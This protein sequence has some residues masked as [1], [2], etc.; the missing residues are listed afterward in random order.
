MYQFLKNVAKAL[1]PKQVLVANEDFF[2]GILK[3]FYRGGEYEC[4]VCENSIKHFI[5]DNTG[6]LCPLC[7]SLPRSR[8]LKHIVFNKYKDGGQ[9][10]LHFS[11][12]RRLKQEFRKL[13]NAYESADFEP[14]KEDLQLDIQNTG[15][16]DDNF[17]LIICFHVLEHV[18]EDRKAISELYRILKKG[19]TVLLQ[20]PFR[21]GDTIED[22]EV[23]DLK[24]RLQL[25][26]QEDHVRWYGFND[27]K[28]RIEAAGFQCE[29]IRAD[30]EMN[31][32]LRLK[33]GINAD[34]RVIAARKL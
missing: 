21:D 15:L 4:S 3:S 14:G 5:Q 10:L 26:G 11:P 13:F 2:R 30:K 18:P 29:L 16:A 12:Q 23:T 25:F 6:E 17:D 8:F 27:F 34:Q 22:P 9:K 24:D 32:E 1:I 7:G 33:N 31:E 20:V 28:G 19:G